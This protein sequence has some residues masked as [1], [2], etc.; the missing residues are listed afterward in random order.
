MKDWIAIAKLTIPDLPAQ[1]IGRLVA[2]LAALEESFRPLAAALTPDQ[3]PAVAFHV[4][5]QAE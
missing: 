4:E 3:E 2:P 5:R 1:D